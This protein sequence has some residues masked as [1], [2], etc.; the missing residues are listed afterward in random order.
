VVEMRGGA[1]KLYPSPDRHAEQI[2]IDELY[3]AM[4]Y[5]RE[6]REMHKKFSS[7]N[8]K[9]NRLEEDMKMYIKLLH[10][11][12]RE[13]DSLLEVAPETSRRLSSA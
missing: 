13:V 5:A 1:D 12:T 7:E 9:E 4:Q 3:G 8:L 2:K 6:T 11:I 10:G